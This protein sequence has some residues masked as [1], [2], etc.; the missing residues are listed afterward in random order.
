MPKTASKFPQHQISIRV[1]DGLARD[2]RTV[3]ARDERSVSDLVRQ[4]LRQGLREI[5]A[6]GDDTPPATIGNRGATR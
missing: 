2:L 6:Q 5:L 4:L 1:G 3:A